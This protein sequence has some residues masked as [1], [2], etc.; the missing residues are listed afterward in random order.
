MTFWQLK[1]YDYMEKLLEEMKAKSEDSSLTQILN[2]L[3]LLSTGNLKEIIGLLNEIIQKYDKSIKML[4]FVGMAMMSKGQIDKATKMYEKVVADLELKKV[5]KLNR[6]KGNTDIIGFLN[7][8]LIC[9]RW[10]D[11]ES[12]NITEC[13]K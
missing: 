1:R 6:M 4:N 12:P 2:C 5:E 10:S 8:Y 9:L 7:N 11:C 13:K 3:Y